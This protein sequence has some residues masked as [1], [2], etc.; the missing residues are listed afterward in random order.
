[1]KITDCLKP[2][3]KPALSFEVVPPERGS[4][5]DSIFKTMDKII[6]HNPRFVSVTNKGCSLEYTCKDG[7]ISVASNNRK[8]GTI[9]VC[10]AI[11]KEFGVETVPHVVC[12]GLDR[13]KTEDLLIDLSFLGFD[14]VFA[15]RG[16]PM[17]ARGAFKYEEE[18]HK[19]AFQLIKQISGLN[20]GI[21]TEPAGGRETVS[22][23][24][25]IGAAG[26]PEKHRE[27]LNREEDIKNFVKKISAGASFTITQAFFGF[28]VYKRFVEIMRVKG[29]CVPVIP[30][31]KPLLSR[32]G[33][34]AVPRIFSATVPHVFLKRMEEAKTPEKERETAAKYMAGL[35]EKLL[36][37]EVPCVHLFTMGKALSTNLLLE[38]F[39]GCFS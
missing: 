10:S 1:M 36:D 25:C 15:V 9:G 22:T 31:L 8:P 27:S 14:N 13:F 38:R 3:A 23:D 39:R 4:S 16:D 28:G 6:A 24:F 26:Y 35:I 30:G 12:A 19:Y 34:E 37:F 32:R 7:K 5:I 11:R 20:R 2:G 18:G 29:I 17:D 33:L 21:Y